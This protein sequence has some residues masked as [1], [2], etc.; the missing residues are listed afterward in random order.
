MKAIELLTSNFGVSQ[1][2]KYSVMKNGEELLAVYW[3]PLTLAEREIIAQKTEKYGGEDY[4]L[5]LLIEKAIDSKGQR[6]FQDG[7][8]AVIRREV[9][10]SILQAIQL[11]MMESGNQKV[12]EEAKADFKSES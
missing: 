10:A 1:K 2:Y 9:D 5:T 6:L 3:H 7:D 8:R 12:V 11:A 4:A